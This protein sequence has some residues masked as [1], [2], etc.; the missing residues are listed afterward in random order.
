MI[1][2]MRSQSG[3]NSPELAGTPRKQLYSSRNNHSPCFPG[4]PVFHSKSKP[5][6]VLL[7]EFDSPRIRARHDVRLEPAAVIGKAV[8]RQGS[9]D[10]VPSC[11]L[12]GLERQAARRIGEVRS[13]Q[14]WRTK[15]H[16]PLD[17]YAFPKKTWAHRKHGC[18]VRWRPADAPPPTNR[19][20]LLLQSLH[21]MSAWYF[22]R[23]EWICHSILEV[24]AHGLRSVDCPLHTQAATTLR[25]QITRARICEQSGAHRNGAS[26]EYPSGRLSAATA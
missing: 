17:S 9:R 16:P 15:Q 25:V 19:K 3:R 14:E 20:G 22:I 12:I 18:L 10:L 2:S 8:K 7:H 26:G 11:R 4:F 13:R 24:K 1:T 21:H 6:P 5:R 23:P